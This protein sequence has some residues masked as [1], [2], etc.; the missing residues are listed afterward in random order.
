MALTGEALLEDALF[1]HLSTLVTDPATTFAW[2]N[3]NHDGSVPRL[4]VDHAPNTTQSATLEGAKNLQGF[5]I[6]T[7]VTETHIGTAYGRDIATQ[8]IDHFPGNLKLHTT[9][10]VI[11][12]NQPPS[13]SQKIIDG[14]EVRF[15]V[16]IPYNAND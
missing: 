16:A 4:E 5:I 8:V 1:R 11:R 10:Y 6:V 7:V 15:P 13:I 9:D 2:P 14:N 3:I 12:F